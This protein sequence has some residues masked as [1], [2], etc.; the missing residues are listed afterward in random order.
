MSEVMKEYIRDL[1]GYVHE[2]AA[3]GLNAVQ[4]RRLHDSLFVLDLISRLF[5]FAYLL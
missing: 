5:S 4:R 2:L 1:I 3:F